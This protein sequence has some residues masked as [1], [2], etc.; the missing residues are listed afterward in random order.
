MA[1]VLTDSS[2]RGGEEWKPF[3]ANACWFLK[4]KVSH[5]SGGGIEILVSTTDHSQ[6]PR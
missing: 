5:V 6:K 4:L 3:N 1:K 2:E